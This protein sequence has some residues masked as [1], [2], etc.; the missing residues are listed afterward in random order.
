LDR[1]RRTSGVPAA[2]SDDLGVELAPLF[3][4]LDAIDAEAAQVREAAE[5]SAT[6]EL[7]T[8]SEEAEA[9]LTGGEEQAEAEWAEAAQAARRAAGADA[10]RI[11]AMGEVE[12]ARIRARGRE[13]IPALAAAV[14]RRIQEFPEQVP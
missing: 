12:A 2:A 14:V 4:L 7:G 10:R 5:R 9:I 11:V 8:A 6:A 13:R 1:F 3:A